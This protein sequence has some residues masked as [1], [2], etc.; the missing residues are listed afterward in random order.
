VIDARRLAQITVVV[1][2]DHQ[3]FAEALASAL[4]DE[5]VRTV[6][7]TTT[8]HKGID[9]ARR[10]RPDLMLVDLGLPDMTG[11]DV[12]RAVVGER[13]ETKV[14]VLTGLYRPE[15]AREALQSGLH[16]Y[17]TKETGLSQLMDAIVS[18]SDGQ[19]VLSRPIAAAVAGARSPEERHWALLAKQL[20]RRERQ[21]LALLA[22]GASSEEI[23]R[24]IGIMP[25]TVRTHVQN[26]LTKLQ[27]H[28][29]LE[30]AA[31][32]TRAGLVD[33]ATRLSELPLSG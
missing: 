18:V 12:G 16:G 21:V 27:V 5:G 6:V 20:T 8:G 7:V 19:T 22:T 14:V 17:L 30:A 26:V 24:R 4:R 9:A 32:A 23:A 11:L 29:R 33:G 28:S 15:S 2:D 25:N 31:F 1:V 10:V 3:L 13:P